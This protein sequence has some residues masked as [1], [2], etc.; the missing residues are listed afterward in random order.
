MKK[1]LAILMTL[2]M[3]LGL[4]AAFAED[5]DPFADES[6]YIMVVGH[7]QSTGHP[8][9]VSLDQFATDVAERTHGHVKVLV[10]PDG[11][12]GTEKEMLEMVVYGTI[13]GLRGGHYDF[14]PRLLMFTLPFLCRNS[15]EVTALLQSDLATEVCM[16]A[17]EATGTVIINLCSAGGFRQFTNNTR[18][19][20]TPADMVGLKLRA[21]NMAPIVFTLEG[22]GASVVSIPF[23]DLYMSLKTGVADGQ[24][25]PWA[26][27]VGSKLYEVQKYF[28]VVN[29]QFHPDPFYVN[30]EWWNSLPVALQD[31]VYECA[32]EMGVYNDALI[33]ANDAALMQQVVDYNNGACQVYI[34]TAEELSAFQEACASVEQKM[35]DAGICTPEEIATMKAIVEAVRA[36]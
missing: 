32:T 1:Y 35:I 17:E 15:D 24:E 19:I 18:E 5:V 34:P 13:Q 33:D 28:T 23:A 6:I 20:K 7:A 4:A 25:N 26:Q 29:Y 8:R 22:L 10:Y 14:S 11:Q 31:I 3:V 16:S 30:A 9:T 2:A 12:L 21:P 27:I 36:E